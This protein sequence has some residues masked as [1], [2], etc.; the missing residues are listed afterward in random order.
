MIETIGTSLNAIVKDD[1]TDGET[2]GSHLLARDLHDVVAI[3]DELR[4]IHYS[5]LC[6]LDESYLVSAK[7]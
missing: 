3:T 2:R 1:H 7:T 6:T 5:S 4:I